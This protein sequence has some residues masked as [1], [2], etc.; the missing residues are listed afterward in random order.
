MTDMNN[1]EVSLMLVEALS[2]IAWKERESKRVRLA[3]FFI[4]VQYRLRHLEQVDYVPERWLVDRD[5]SPVMA[6]LRERDRT[7]GRGLASRTVD[8]EFVARHSLAETLEDQP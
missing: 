2:G 5:S 4:E 6:D 7:R 3:A 8:R 1:G